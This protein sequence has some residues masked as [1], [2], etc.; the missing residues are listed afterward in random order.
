METRRDRALV[1]GAGIAG[2]LAARALAEHFASVVVVER[3]QLPAAPLHR[4]GVPHGRHVHGLLPG[5]LLLFE[6]L[7][8]GLVEEMTGRGA[9]VGDV[10]QN[11]RWYVRGRALCR[12][13]AG[14]M[15]LSAS[16]P[17]IEAV[18]RDRLLLRPNVSMRGGEEAVAL[19]FTPNGRRVTG[20]EVVDRVTGSRRTLAADLTVDATGRGSRAQRWLTGFGYPEPPTDQVTIDLWYGS[21]LFA[22]APDVFGD[23]IMV[24][25]ARMPKQ[26]RSGI[27]QRI[28]DGRVL[29]T[30]AGIRGDRPPRDLT[31]FGD[32]AGTLAVP[33]IHRLVTSGRPLAAPVRFHCPTYERRRYE[34]VADY[35]AGLLPIGD[36]MCSFNPGYAEGMSVAARSATVLGD[37][38][39][40]DGEPDSSAF[41]A[42]V[43]EIIDAP[44][45]SGV[46]ADLPGVVGPSSTG[47]L[48]REY[49]AD[50]E[51]AA[52]DDA[53]LSRAFVRVAG[54]VDPPSALL[55]DAVRDRM[56]RVCAT[57]APAA[58]VHR[59]V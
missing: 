39:R 49:M 24:S 31:G 10:L 46:R 57:P 12:A 43:T 40:A 47:Q 53:M 23:D 37:Q 33:D 38:L 19:C 35:P 55:S 58:R 26:R 22:A 16:R 59:P 5:G 20:A 50:L 21:C 9:M 2:L 45:N 8:P 51:R 28:E 18:V 36:A 11:I 14:L 30:L 1:L 41:F 56:A 29:V 52:P 32:F 15:V 6:R 7:L 3:D 54:L 34:Q 25:I 17:L 44:W 27:M 42:A 13:D 48:N 4:R